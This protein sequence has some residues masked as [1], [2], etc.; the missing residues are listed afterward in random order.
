[1]GAFQAT[2]KTLASTLSNMESHWKV[3]SKGGN[4]LIPF[5]ESLLAAALRTAYGGWGR[6][7][8]PGG[9]DNQEAIVE[10]QVGDEATRI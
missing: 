8:G 1:M 7:G 5:K 10:T 9:W 3:L 4:H 2:L 6:A